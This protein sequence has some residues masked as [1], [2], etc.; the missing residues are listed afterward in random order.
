M[1]EKNKNKKGFSI[2]SRLVEFCS[3]LSCQDLKP[4]VYKLVKNC[5]KCLKCDWLNEA[6]HSTPKSKKHQL[7]CTGKIDANWGE[8]RE[9]KNKNLKALY[10]I[11]Q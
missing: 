3:K 7:A 9:G 10:G 6:Q 2:N 11:C 8:G 4:F 5:V 1:Y